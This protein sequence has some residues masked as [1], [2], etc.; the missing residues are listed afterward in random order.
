MPDYQYKPG[1]MTDTYLLE[2]VK[3][4]WKCEETHCGTGSTHKETEKVRR[5]LPAIAADFGVLSVADA[6]AGD[7]HWIHLVEWEVFDYQGYDLFP[8]HPDVIQFDITK[9]VLPRVDLILCRHVL[10]H[11]SIE[12]AQRALDLF[13]DSESAYLLMTNCDNQAAYWKEYGLSFGRPIQTYDDC[14]HWRLELYDCLSP[15]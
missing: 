11:L 4:G 1:D 6:G 12:Y 5:I 7:L 3:K 13:R 8:R 14:Q 15:D 2:K 10:N 9:Q